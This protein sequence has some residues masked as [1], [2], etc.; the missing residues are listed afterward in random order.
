MALNHESLE[1]GI[2]T[3]PQERRR[4]LLKLFI[5]NKIRPYSE[6]IAGLQFH[7]GYSKVPSRQSLNAEHISRSTPQ[8]SLEIASNERKTVDV[9]PKQPQK[10]QIS[11]RSRP[12]HALAGAIHFT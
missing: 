12:Q 7:A 2:I 1:S 11:N 3:S 5:F 8:H 10:P 9:S 6:K 4:A